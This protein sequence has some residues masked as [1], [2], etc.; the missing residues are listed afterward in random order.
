M[1][2]GASFDIRKRIVELQSTKKE[3]HTHVILQSRGICV[4]GLKYHLPIHEIA[5]HWALHSTELCNN[6]FTFQVV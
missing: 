2:L 5:S 1:C 6:L 3:G 4:K